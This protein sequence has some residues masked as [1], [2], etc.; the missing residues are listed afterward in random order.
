MACYDCE[1]CSKSIEYGGKCERFEYDL[2]TTVHLQCLKTIVMRN[3][4]Q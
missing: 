3:L 2:N 4:N 1:D